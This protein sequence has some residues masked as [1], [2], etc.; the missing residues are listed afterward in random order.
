MLAL[1][2]VSREPKRGSKPLVS[3]SRFCRS[4]NLIMRNVEDFENLV[5]GS[6]GAGKFVA[7]TEASADVAAGLLE[8]FTD[9]GI[10]VLLGTETFGLVEWLR[11]SQ[12]RADSASAN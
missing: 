10:E 5:V 6:G 2:T 7:W 9:E 12:V 4:E 11:H 3:L 8:L 1:R